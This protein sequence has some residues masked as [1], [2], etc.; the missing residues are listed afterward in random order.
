MLK[1]K[2]E[3]VVYAKSTKK[4]L[5]FYEDRVLDLTKFMNTHPGGKKA[6]SN[7]L[8]KDITDTVFAVY[9]HKR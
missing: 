1:R 4:Q 2:E 9:P 6:L 7:Y 5:F 3:W 8:L